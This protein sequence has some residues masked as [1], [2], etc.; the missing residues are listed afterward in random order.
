M[1]L[2]LL[3]LILVVVA[4]IAV[5][6]TGLVD[7]RQT[8]PAEVPNVEAENG[9]RATG[10]QTPAFD[11]ETGSVSVGATQQNVTLPMPTVDINPANSGAE[12]DNQA[13]NTN[14]Q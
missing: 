9:I 11:I 3:I 7:I 8:R 14:S 4:L 2:I 1:R 10:G 13:A 6:A 12:A 5:V